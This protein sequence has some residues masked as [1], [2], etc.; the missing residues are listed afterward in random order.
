MLFEFVTKL[1]KELQGCTA[2]TFC[3]RKVLT[4]AKRFKIKMTKSLYKIQPNQSILTSKEILNLAYN[5]SRIYNIGS[6]T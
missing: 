6:I 1:W 5:N 2:K 3:N 4:N